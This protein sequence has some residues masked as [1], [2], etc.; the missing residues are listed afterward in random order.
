[1]VYHKDHT[2]HFY[3][4]HNSVQGSPFYC[5]VTLAVFKNICH[6]LEWQLSTLTLHGNPSPPTYKNPM[7]V[8]EFLMSSQRRPIPLYPHPPLPPQPESDISNFPPIQEYQSPCSQTESECDV[9]DFLPILVKNS[10]DQRDCGQSSPSLS[11]TS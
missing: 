5:F 10:P 11:S 3:C 7:I 6:S 9:S 1:M 2:L 8:S 4:L